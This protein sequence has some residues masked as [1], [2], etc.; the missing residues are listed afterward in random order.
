MRNVEATLWLRELLVGEDVLEGGPCNVGL[1]SL[2]ATLLA[3]AARAELP[4]GVRKI[5]GYHT[6]GQDEMVLLYSR[7]ALAGPL[8]AL[9]RLLAAIRE[10][11]FLPAEGRS[12][13][14]LCEATAC[15]AAGKE[16]QWA[17]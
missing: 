16:A 8:R 7:D 4:V 3:W 6:S 12:G 13:L 5:L 17:T 10:G 2:K 14:W 11:A 9:M 1:H 15:R